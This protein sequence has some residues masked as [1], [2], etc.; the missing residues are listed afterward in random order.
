MHDQLGATPQ[1]EGERVQR[2][3]RV[4]DV[5][6]DRAR[7]APDGPQPPEQRSVAPRGDG[8]R[9][10]RVFGRAEDDRVRCRA[11]GLERLVQPAHVPLEPAGAVGEPAGAD[12]QRLHRAHDGPPALADSLA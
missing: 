10:R 3:M 7:H 1:K 4:D 11:F 8:D 6:V 2:E 9:G 12:Q 5:G